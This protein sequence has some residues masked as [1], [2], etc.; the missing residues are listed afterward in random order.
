MSLRAVTSRRWGAGHPEQVTVRHPRW[1]RRTTTHEPPFQQ[2]PTPGHLR[3]SDE[4]GHLVGL[5]L[6]RRGPPPPR[7]GW[8]EVAGRPGLREAQDGDQGAPFL[9]REVQE[10]AAERCPG[11]R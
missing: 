9:P 4:L 1:Y 11:H 6:R 7:E 3:A 5:L 8:A 2:A 10:A